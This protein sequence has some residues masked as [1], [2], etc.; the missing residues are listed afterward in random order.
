MTRF[1]RSL[2]G[3]L[4]F[5]EHGKEGDNMAEPK[6]LL[7]MEDDRVL[8]NLNKRVLAREGY[9]VLVARNQ[10][11]AWAEIENNTPQVI[12]LDG[13]L[14]DVNI[15]DFCR[16]LRETRGTPIVFLTA[17]DGDEHKKAGHDAGADDY[18]TKPYRMERLTDSIEALLDRKNCP[19]S[20][21]PSTA[22][23]CL[24]G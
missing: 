3:L 12:V 14:A 7:L 19:H 11:E 18:I 9:R 20:P 8:V 24:P 6:T 10:N 15:F 13:E 17:L 22:K 2:S 5:C 23:R 1:T 4:F 16:E 21:K